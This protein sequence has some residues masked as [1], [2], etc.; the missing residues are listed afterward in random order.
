MRHEAIRRLIRTRRIPTQEALA[1]ELATL[2]FEVT[3][4]TLSRD[5]ARLRAVRIAQAD[6]G[7]AY[8]LGMAPLSG[9]EQLQEMGEMVISISDNGS[10]VVLLTQPGAASAVARAIDL[11]RL[12]ESLGSLAGDDTIFLAPSRA[13][14]A[15]KLA[16]RLRALFGKLPS[17]SGRGSG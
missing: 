15:E 2:G 12:S 5:L 10:L 11:A 1:Q 17:P 16:Q 13:T 6:G 8:E 14:S 3:Q 4:A 7:T 9:A